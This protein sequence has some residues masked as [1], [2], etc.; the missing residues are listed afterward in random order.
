MRSLL[1]AE[2]RMPEMG[3]TVP[4]GVHGLLATDGR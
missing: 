2:L 4:W 3:G 1:L